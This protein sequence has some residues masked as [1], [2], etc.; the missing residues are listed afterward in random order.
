V[1]YSTKHEGVAQGKIKEF[2]KNEWKV[3]L[4]AWLSG[5]IL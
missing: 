3:I 1:A 5:N 2:E 4:H